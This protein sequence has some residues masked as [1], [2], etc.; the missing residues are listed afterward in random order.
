MTWYLESNDGERVP[1]YPLGTHQLPSGTYTFFYTLDF[2]GRPTARIAASGIVQ[3][4]LGA[5]LICEEDE[6]GQRT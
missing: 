5:R 1:A 2:L 6:N 3:S 4:E